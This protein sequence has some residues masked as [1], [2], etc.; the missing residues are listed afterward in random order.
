MIRFNPVVCQFHFENLTIF[1]IL[2]ESMTQ[3]EPYPDHSLLQ[4]EMLHK[5]LEEIG[6][7][8][9]S[10]SSSYHQMNPT[11]IGFSVHSLTKISVFCFSNII[12]HQ[13]DYILRLSNKDISNTSFFLSLSWLI[14]RWYEPPKYYVVDEVSPVV[15]VTICHDCSTVGYDYSLK[16]GAVRCL[17]HI[18]NMNFTTLMVF[19]NLLAC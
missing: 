15:Q 11:S 4:V 17:P 7:L 8:K 3:W 9:D 5:G 13:S 16:P 12:W 10:R 1:C 19:Q 14:K 6:I 18:P 2:W